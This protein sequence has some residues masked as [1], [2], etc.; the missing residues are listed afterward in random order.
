MLL[1]FLPQEEHLLVTGG[2]TRMCQVQMKYRAVT[3]KE[4]EY[5]A[6]EV[7]SLC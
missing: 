7:Y 5:Q 2:F 4:I 3:L 6:F 1:A